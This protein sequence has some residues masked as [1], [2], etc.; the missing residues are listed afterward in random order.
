MSGF[1]GTDFI[2]SN[3]GYG[4]VK[5]DTCNT[6]D[7]G[8]ETIVFQADEKHN[9]LSSKDLFVKHYASEEDAIAGHN[10]ILAEWRATA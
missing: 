10:Q 9:V 1:H 2:L 7:S 5:V 8:W 3:K 6:F 4:Y